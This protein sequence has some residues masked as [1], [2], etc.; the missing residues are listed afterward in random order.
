MKLEVEVRVKRPSGFGLDA[1]LHCDTDALGVVGPS[2]SGKSTLLDAIAG[3]D[4]GARVALDG[5]D[6]SGVPTARRELG[7]VSQDPILF[8]HLSVRGNLRYSPRAGPI[9]GVASALKID[10]LLDSMP[11]HLS[12]GERRR[13]ALARALASRPRLLLLDEP[14]AGLDETRRRDA[15]S[16]LDEVR[17]RLSVPIILVSHRSDEIVA[18]TDWSI[19]LE[20]GKV[21]ASGPSASLLRRS[22][23]LVDNFL[24]GVVRAPGRVLLDGTDGIEL[25]AMLPEG[26]RGE[27]RLACYAHDVMLATTEPRDLSARNVLPVTVSQI[28][29]EGDLLL[30]EVEPPRLRVLVTR[31]AAETL[32]LRVGLRAHAILKATSIVYLGAS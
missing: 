32:G 18:L 4:R 12:G 31:D 22:E 19:R 24:S 3:L 6:L 11:R 28:L 10:H 5:V 26:V 15:L 16:L 7:Y 9:D 27:V 30:I 2:G 1:S 14:F 23:T 17:R 8:P 25:S 29:G 13:V 20:D 21:D